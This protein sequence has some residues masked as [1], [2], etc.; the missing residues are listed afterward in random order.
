MKI[1][2]KGIH[3]SKI[4]T[5]FLVKSPFLRK[6]SKIEQNLQAFWSFLKKMNVIRRD[7]INPEK[8]RMNSIIYLRN[9]SK[10]SKWGRDRTIGN[11]MKILEIFGE[12][13]LEFVEK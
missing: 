4:S 12:N 3:F 10:S 7:P 6:I 13:R 1:I 2:R 9:L 5:F 8:F 11:G